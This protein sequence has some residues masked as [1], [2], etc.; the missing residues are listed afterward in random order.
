MNSLQINSP[1]YRR[2]G[3]QPG[4]AKPLLSEGRIEWMPPPEYSCEQPIELRYRL[5]GPPGAPVIVALGGIS[6]NSQ[7]QCWWRGLYGCGRTLDPGRWGVLGMDWALAAAA[8]STALQ[9]DALAALFD[10]LGLASVDVLLGA[11]YG[12][13]VGLSFAARH[14]VRL[15]RL[16]AISGA[17]YSR[18]G[19]TALRIVQREI[20]GLGRLGGQVRRGLALARAL[21]MTGYR[22]AALFDDRFAAE[23]PDEM[24]T[25]VQS[26]LDHHGRVFSENND[27]ERYCRL[28]ESLDRH[29]VDP[30]SIRCPV[31]LV[32]IESDTLVP[33]GQMEALAGQ[34]GEHARLHR[35]ASIYGHDAFLKEDQRLN[36]LLSR[37]LEQD[38]NS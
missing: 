9:A 4:P 23:D 18:P 8:T 16:V 15:Q 10:H 6:A 12:A 5:A 20:V 35:M 30:A 28:S 1:G 2:A 17:D 25:A 22:P 7:V 11:S 13:M 31:D 32:A 29:R 19:S 38:V 33:V 24:L 26:Y 14:D 36:T 37:L 27:A 21:A 34:L 3:P